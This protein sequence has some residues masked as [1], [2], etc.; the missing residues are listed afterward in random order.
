MFQASA[1]TSIPQGGNV[2]DAAGTP[3][4]SGNFVVGCA[5]GNFKAEDAWKPKVPIHPLWTDWRPS[6]TARTHIAPSRA[7]AGGSASPAAGAATPHYGSATGSGSTRG[8]TSVPRG[9]DA[10]SSCRTVLCGDPQ[11]IVRCPVRAKSRGPPAGAY[12]HPIGSV[13]AANA[14]QRSGSRRP[15]KP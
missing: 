13:G 8:P 10:A 4:H 11:N 6:S 3:L 9:L 14:S 2:S 7:M 5:R 12:Q 15:Y 1:V